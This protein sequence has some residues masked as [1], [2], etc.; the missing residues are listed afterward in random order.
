MDRC[1]AHERTEWAY[2]H[3]SQ[4]SDAQWA[5]LTRKDAELEARVKQLEAEKKGV[6]DADYMPGQFKDDPDLAYSNEYVDAVYNPEEVEEE[7]VGAGTAIMVILGVL[8]IGCVV[9]FI[10]FKKWNY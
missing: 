4:I 3:R 1:D 8:I 10:F 5:E 6:R 2:H 9:F 7:G